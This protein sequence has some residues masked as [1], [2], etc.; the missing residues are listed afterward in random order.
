[1]LWNKM[2]RESLARFAIS[3]TALFWLCMAVV[4]VQDEIRSHL[5]NTSY[6]S[7]IWGAIYKA[8]VSDIFILLVMVLGLGGL[9]QERAQGT[10]SFTLSLPVSRSRLIVV[11]AAVGFVE[12]ALLALIPALAIPVMSVF[13]GEHYPIEYALQSSLLWTICGSVF[14][15]V[16]LFF[17]AL[18]P[19]AYV[20]M[21]ASVVATLLYSVIADLPALE[22]FESA[23]LID[24]MQRTDT[25]SRTDGIY[26]TP[27]WASLP[28][29]SLAVFGVVA[30]G[31]VW[32]ACGV[33]NRWDL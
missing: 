28:W 27:A 21:V 4:I 26:A 3:A 24:V 16:S 23:S 25:L 5:A 11:R 7:Y 9:L 17:S 29:L 30:C 2:W 22:R 19:G 10:I 6:A 31:L 1:V 13:V 33:A 14:F 12:V 8:N 15:A 20:P 32:A 18:M